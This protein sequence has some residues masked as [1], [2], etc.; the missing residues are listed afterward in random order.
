LREIAV[1]ELKPTWAILCGWCVVASLSYHSDVIPS[2]RSPGSLHPSVSF[3]ARGEVDVLR[4]AA[5]APGLAPFSQWRYRIKS[6]LVESTGPAL[7]ELDL[8]P[9]VIEER[10]K[11][12]S[13][14]D[15]IAHRH[16]TSPPMRC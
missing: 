1:F 3:Q 10:W 9:A 14:K 8:G 7:E 11:S 2:S 5:R 4:T 12:V 15:L 13:L 6:V 16:P